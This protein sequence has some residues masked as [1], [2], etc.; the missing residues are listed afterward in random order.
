MMEER[1]NL[2]A[3]WE[4]MKSTLRIF[5]CTCGHIMFED[6]DEHCENVIR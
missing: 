5:L 2:G 6:L 1:C 3:Y 4:T